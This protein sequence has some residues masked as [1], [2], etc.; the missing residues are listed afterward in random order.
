MAVTLYYL[1]G[2]P[3]AWRAW[4]TLEYKGIAYELRPMSFDAGDFKKPAFAALSPRSRV[5]VLVD[6][7]FALYESA[8]IV[9]YLEDKWPQPPLLSADIRQRAIERR[10]IREADQYFAAALEQLVDAILFTPPDKWSD[11]DIAKGAAGVA[12]ELALW[13]T[14]IVGDYLAGPLSLADFTLYPELALV[15]RIAKRKPDLT[16]ADW[17][18]PKMRAWSARMAALPVVQKTWPPHWKT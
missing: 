14:A 7:G 1:S 15:Q 16:V 2:S 11:E 10:M 18:G 17:L 8:A 5:P 12:A 4:L 9:E 3:Y 6:E 13:E